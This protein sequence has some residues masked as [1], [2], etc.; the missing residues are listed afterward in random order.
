MFRFSQITESNVSALEILAFSKGK[1]GNVCFYTIEKVEKLSLK[2]HFRYG[3]QLLIMK[4]FLP[5]YV[6]F[7]LSFCI[8]PG[9]QE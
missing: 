9:G 6:L 4:D 2:L 5:V 7:I 3:F 8:S 1:T